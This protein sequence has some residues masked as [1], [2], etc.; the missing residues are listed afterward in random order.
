MSILG[1]KAK[2][3]KNKLRKT[4]RGYLILSFV[5]IGVN[6]I[7]GIFGHGVH[8]PAMT[9]MFLYPLLGGALVFLLIERL[10]S[11]ITRF[12]AYRMGYNSYNS[13][14]AALTIGSFLKGILDIAGTNSP[15]LVFFTGMG[16]LFIAAGVA[17]FIILAVNRQK[18]QTTIRET[19]ECQ[20]I[21]E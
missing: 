1:I 5:A 3:Q 20:S 11:G 19:H 15:Y 10:T 16:W 8:S 6:F 14:I 21:I 12:A 13:G 18:I 4:I 9:W 17:I 2:G 7:Y